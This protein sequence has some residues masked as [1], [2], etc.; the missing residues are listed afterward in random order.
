MPFKE[1]YERFKSMSV[2]SKLT[3]T[4]N[5]YQTKYHELKEE[6]KL[7][8]ELHPQS[9]NPKNNKTEITEKKSDSWSQSDENSEDELDD[10]MPQDRK[11]GFKIRTKN[12][13]IRVIKELEDDDI[14]ITLSEKTKIE[15]E[16]V[17]IF[18]HG[19]AGF[20]GN[21]DGRQKYLRAWSKYHN[22]PIFSINYRK[23]PAFKYPTQLN[24]IINGYVW[25]LT[26]VE[27]ILG[28]KVKKL[29]VN[30]DSFGANNAI[31]LTNWCIANG[32][33]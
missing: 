25:I 4:N 20:A 5:M 23:T 7:Y 28:I 32:I 14:K 24:D 31:A 3:K 11:T 13:E 22:I 1:S 33:R 27:S 8:K 15:F 30:G 2:N 12:K 17:M 9:K 6:E 16:N 18:I 29:I 10:K 26:F 21:S 19:G